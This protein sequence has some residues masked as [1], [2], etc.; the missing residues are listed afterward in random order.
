ML[1]AGLRPIVHCP[2]LANI[3]EVCVYEE[4]LSATRLETPYELGVQFDAGY[5]LWIRIVEMIVLGLVSISILGSYLWFIGARRN[6]RD[7]LNSTDPLFDTLMQG[8]FKPNRPY[9]QFTNARMSW[10]EV[11]EEGDDPTIFT[12]DLGYLGHCHMTCL[13]GESGSGKTSFIKTIC[14]YEVGHV[15]LQIGEWLKRD[16]A[17]LC[18]QDVSMWPKEMIV[19]DILLF[20]CKM[21]DVDTQ[22]YNDSFDTLGLNE[23]MDQEFSTLSGGQQQRVSIAATIVRKE[24]TL[25]FLDGTFERYFAIK[26]ISHNLFHDYLL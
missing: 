1:S 26:N 19:R 12:C 13:T 11:N 6:F 9:I 22:Y 15:K 16:A 4:C 23:L 3:S 7:V 24:P 8:D 21:N 25:I 2:H 20:A 17:T 18:P 5:S 14:G 10:A